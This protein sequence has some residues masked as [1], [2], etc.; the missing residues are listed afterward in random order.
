MEAA[1][2][3]ASIPSMVGHEICRQGSD[4]QRIGDDQDWQSAADFLG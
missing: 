2:R 1:V 4:G 3:D